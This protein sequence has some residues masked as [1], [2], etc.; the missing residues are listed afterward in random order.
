MAYDY[1]QDGDQD[2]P[3]DEANEY[4]IDKALEL[5]NIA[6]V[7]D[8]DTLKTIGKVTVEEYLRDKDSRHD[9]EERHDEW[10]KIALMFSERKTFPW[11]NASNVKYPL[12]ATAAQ[13]F[14][15]R[16]YPALCPE[17][18]L[19]SGK[20]IGYDPDGSVKQKAERIGMHMSWQIMEKMYDWEEG[21]DR[22][23]NCVPISGTVFKKV[24]YDPS[25]KMN[26][27]EVVLPKDLVI[28]Y[29]AKDLCQAE[30]ITHILPFTENEIQERINRGLYLD[31][32]LS[33]PT[34]PKQ[35]RVQRDMRGIDESSTK[36]DSTPY[37]VLECH[38][39]WDLDGD[40]Y[41]EPYIITV[42]EKTQKV[43]RITA[44]FRKDG[45][46]KSS[47]G[48]IIAIRPTEFFVKFPFIPNPDGGIYDIG[49]GHLLSG[50]NE[51]VNTLLNQLIDSGTI[52]NLQAGFI[53]KGIRIKG[54][55]KPFS[56][57]EW[58]VT[59]SPGDDLR[60]GI[61]PLP[62]REPS[63]VLLQLLGTMVQSGK[64]LA[65]VAEI[66]VGK[67]PGQNTPATTTQ[68][69]VEQGMKVFTA[70]YKRLYRAMKKEFKLLFELNQIYLDASEEFTIDNY[71]GAPQ[72]AGIAPSDYQD[73][74]INVIP[75]ADPSVVSDSQKLNKVQGLMSLLQLGTVNP[76]EVTKEFLDAI[77]CTNIQQLTQMPPPQPNFDQQIEQQKIQGKQQYEQGKLALEQQALNND[78]MMQLKNLQLEVMKLRE[79]SDRSN[80]QHELEVVKAQHGVVDSMA[81]NSNT[82]VEHRLKH[83]EI[84][85]KPTPSEQNR[86][87]V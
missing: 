72:S 31:V 78:L 40:G 67:M 85:R 84:L 51:S 12:I 16:A 80:R 4:K 10:M 26:V 75:A 15:A 55:N 30:R 39:F 50:L 2:S 9:W 35:S 6:E 17:Q 5:T 37:T 81:A 61:F 13:Q 59:E 53:S 7:I 68:V 86:P 23:L 36:D 45:I 58:K 48:K 28:N 8:E 57:G 21:M 44:R 3:Q 54:G 34:P 74:K 18:G 60:K 76:Q 64:E 25:C 41:N 73:V 63:A 19:V 71:Q 38:R 20:V 65:S 82:H 66:M 79:E 29:Y 32:N 43:L 24:W 70:I 83:M 47:S 14:A 46:E 56:P 11:P 62:V 33:D 52:S 69:A 1:D 27:S 42:E 49:F 22:L 77:G 87:K